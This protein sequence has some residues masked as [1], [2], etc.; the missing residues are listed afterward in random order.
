MSNVT[1]SVQKYRKELMQYEEEYKALKMLSSE[2]NDML[3]DESFMSNLEKDIRSTDQSILKKRIT[4]RLFN[5]E[6]TEEEERKLPAQG[7]GIEEGKA[8]LM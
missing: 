4:S 1:Y 8:T 5:S 7:F 2:L 3:V 6:L